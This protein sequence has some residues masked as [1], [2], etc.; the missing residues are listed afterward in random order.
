MKVDIVK[1]REEFLGLSFVVVN[2]LKGEKEIYLLKK[3]ER[4]SKIDKKIII[5]FKKLWFFRV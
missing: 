2:D 1:V 4:N 5:S 3:F